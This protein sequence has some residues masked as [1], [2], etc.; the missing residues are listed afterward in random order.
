MGF[1]KPD[2]NA[3]R[4]MQ[5]QFQSSKSN[6]T[7]Y[8]WASLP[9]KGETI[10]VRFLPPVG[11]MN[12]PFFKLYKHYQVPN[13]EGEGTLNFT[14][15]RTWNM[16]CPICSKIEHLKRKFGDDFVNQWYA[17]MRGFFNV[18][19][20]DDPNYVSGLPYI[21]G[22]PKSGLIWFL[23]IMGDEDYGD[24]TDPYTGFWVKISR[25]DNNQLRFDIVPKPSPIASTDEE[26]NQIAEQC[27]DLTK[28]WRNPDDEYIITANKIADRIE[29]IVKEKAGLLET[30][31][32]VVET[33]NQV[34]P[35]PVNITKPTPVPQPTQPKVEPNQSSVQ[36]P[37][38][39][40]DC[41][42]NFNES[43]TR[44]LICIHEIECRQATQ[45]G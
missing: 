41:F 4:Q 8:R 12:L 6:Q 29:A 18:L 22:M 27:F 24:I 15:L 38:G 26:I 23:G 30:G 9:E 19:I 7:D 10:K 16:E 1:K 17:S 34:N 31:K 25:M 36:K 45:G 39:A 33:P 11:E 44:C 21:L 32:S 3:I 35:N 37:P 42:G 40:P 20:K 43:D 2:L 14:C 28:I 13:P 5:E